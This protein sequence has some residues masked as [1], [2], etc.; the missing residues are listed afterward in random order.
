MF[1]SMSWMS[2]LFILV[3]APLL[4][5]KF[6]F[7]SKYEFPLSEVFLSTVICFFAVFICFQ[8]GKTMKSEDLLIRNGEVTGKKRE[9]GT[10]TRFESCNCNKNGC[11]TCSYTVYTVDWLAITNIGKIRVDYSESRSSLVYASSDPAIYKNIVVGEPAAMSKSYVNYVK[12]MPTS[13][14]NNQSFKHHKYDKMIP[15]YPDK[16]HEKYKINRVVKI[17]DVKVNTSDWD[18]KL[19]VAL[20]DWGFKRKSNVVIVLTNE[21]VDFAT[22]LNNKW[23]NGRQNDVVI[24]LGL[25]NNSS[26]LSWVKTLGWVSSERF[27]LEI[28]DEILKIKE[29]LTIDEILKVL[30]NKMPSFVE[31]NI[32]EEFDYLKDMIQP[33]PIWLIYTI[34]I[35]LAACWLAIAFKRKHMH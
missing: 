5:K 15:E 11:S 19:S 30:D 13:L 6:F 22:A 33:H 14:F 17:G 27:K 28:A 23:L 31:R 34:L 10:E 21:A 24:V 18:S 25:E 26:K 29:N 32:E 35:T 7:K 2:L 12:A 20:K 16:I 4:I 3:L 1:T 9:H 8:L